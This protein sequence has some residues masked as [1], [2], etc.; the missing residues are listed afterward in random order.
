MKQPILKIN[1]NTFIVNLLL[2]DTYEKIE[3]ISAKL[4]ELLNNTLRLSDDLWLN[5]IRISFYNLN[6]E[7][8]GNSFYITNTLEEE[9]LREDWFIELL[10]SKSNIKNEELILMELKIN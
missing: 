1:Q 10:S 4:G 2:C 6:G 3:I 5:C 9:I 8:L 7:L